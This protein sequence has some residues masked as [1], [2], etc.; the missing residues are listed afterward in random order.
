MAPALRP[1]AVEV[2]RR[3]G[4]LP[5]ETIID[6]GTGT[7]TAAALA[8]G[9]GRVVIGLD[10]A[11]GMLEVARRQHP[12]LELLEADFTH[13]PMA[14]GS[15]DVV[16]A[17]HAL[18]F[19]DDRVSA[20]REWLRLARP[21][22]R[23]SLSV[24]GPGSVVPTAVLGHVY[25]RYGLTWGD[26]YPTQAELA[27]WGA[28]AGWAEIR[29]AADGTMGIPLRDDDHFRTWLSVGS[30]GRATADWSE[31]RK[32]AFARDL[33]AAAPRGAD[34]GYLLPFGALYLTAQRAT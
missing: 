8:Q 24:P 22:G 1:V 13:V 32:G 30:R 18:L 19:A 21:G 20:L 16:L 28:E 17:V 14:D 27:G 3:A 31:E 2:V 34:G 4:L 26:D 11:S 7:G 9:T 5:G 10:A 15:V 33:M 12:E 6:M 23:L 25:D 29:T